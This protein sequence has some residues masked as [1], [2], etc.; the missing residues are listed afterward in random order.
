MLINRFGD[1][2]FWFYHTINVKST[3]ICERV[4][5]YLLPKTE[6]IRKTL[7]C[8]LRYIVNLQVSPNF[9]QSFYGI[10]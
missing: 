1:K 4:V 8:E 2:S 10:I 9:L 5:W 6:M 3:F 7:Y